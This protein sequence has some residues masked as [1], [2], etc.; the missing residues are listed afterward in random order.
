MNDRYDYEEPSRSP[1]CSFTA[2]LYT[3]YIQNWSHDATYLQYQ[4]SVR[5]QFRNT[6]TAAVPAAAPS[7]SS[8]LLLSV[9]VVCLCLCSSPVVCTEH[10]VEKLVSNVWTWWP[11]LAGLRP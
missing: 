5:W 2:I 3:A 4:Q 9:G 11:V 8:V 7:L 1:E 6:A 10:T